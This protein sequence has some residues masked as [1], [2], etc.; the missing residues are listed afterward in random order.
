M[1]RQFDFRNQHPGIA[2]DEAGEVIPANALLELA[3]GDT[4]I[5]NDGQERTVTRRYGGPRGEQVVVSDGPI[6]RDYDDLQ[7]NQP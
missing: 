2:V 7:P 3:E 1:P 6:S 5:D 4:W